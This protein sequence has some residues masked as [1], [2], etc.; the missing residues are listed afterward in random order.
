MKT[1][2]IVLLTLLWLADAALAEPLKAG[3]ARVDITP[4][5]GFPMWG[6][7]V[8]HDEPSVKV[9]DPLSARAVVLAVGANKMALVS[10]DLGRA[11]TRQSMANIRKQ[12]KE[13]TQIETIFLVASHTH[14]GPVLELDNWPN[15]EKP[16][17]RT[18]EAQIVKAIADADK[19]LQPA[20]LG[21]SAH[22][23]PFN[24]NRHSKRADRPLDKEMVLV[25]IEDVRG[26]PIAHLV[27]FAAHPVML[28]ARLREFSH[29]YPGFLAAHVEKELGGQCLFLQGAAGDLSVDSQ[30]A[31]GPEE[32]G[33]LFGKFIVEK[34]RA[35]KCD[36][37]DAGPIKARERDFKFTSRIDIRNP[38]VY[39]AYAYAF[40]PALVDFYEREYREGV[41]PHMTAALVDGRIGFVG[42][43]GEL[44]TSHAIQ[45]KRRA[46]LDHLLIFGYCNDYQ[47]YFPTIEA[48][49]EGGYG[50]DITVAPA[51]VGAGERIM[52]QALIDLYEMR[53][54]IRPQKN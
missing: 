51:E 5:V 47:Q 40:F 36:L 18:L 37:K 41:R 16:Y 14:H 19:A 45:L 15:K 2:A 11:P 29:D 9:R 46:R 8:R 53:G 34:S 3:A 28:P 21:V 26:K 7:A 20:R 23:V 25:R 17:L 44:F 4:P 6:Y 50:A 22:Q 33:A 27:N 42:V 12:L 31:K 48:V 54:K 30:G 32:F 13:S 38:I 24:R 49:A 43:S 52:D 35:M 1:Q 39:A 10:L